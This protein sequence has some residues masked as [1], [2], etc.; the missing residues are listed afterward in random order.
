MSSVNYGNAYTVFNYQY[1]A[2]GK[3]FSKIL[4]DVIFGG[5]YTGGQLSYDGTDVIIASYSALYETNDQTLKVTTSSNI[6]L[7]TVVGLSAITS[8]TPYVVASITWVDNTI[9]YPDY[10]FKSLASITSSDIVFGKATFSGSVVTGFV[11]DETTYGITKERSTNTWNIPGT[12]LQKNIPIVRTRLSAID[13]NTIFDQ[14]SND[15]DIYFI[16]TANRTADIRGGSE[17]IG[18]ELNIYNYTTTNKILAI[19]YKTGTIVNLEQNQFIKFKW[20][21]ITWDIVFWSDTIFNIDSNL[22]LSTA[23]NYSS[24][25]IPA[26]TNR[27]INLINGSLIIGKELIVKNTAA[28]ESYTLDTTYNSGKTV[29]IS[30]GSWIKFRWNGLTWDI[31]EGCGS[32]IPIMGTTYNVTSY[33]LYKCYYTITG[34]IVTVNGYFDLV[35]DTNYAAGCFFE[36]SIPIISNFS[37]NCDCNGVSIGGSF[38]EGGVFAIRADVSSQTAHFGDFHIENPQD[39]NGVARKFIFSYIIK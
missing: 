5:L 11:Y 6:L 39:P 18:D 12:V 20:T 27:T 29:S 30:A 21:G 31:I 22:T 19:T 28:S 35:K 38:F 10:S 7:N 17:T 8:V 4:K 3:A 25:E 36:I 2:T 34:N 14:F 26:S 1:D 32:Y 33:T 37:S 13:T 15:T 23:N 24:I 16:C 9:L